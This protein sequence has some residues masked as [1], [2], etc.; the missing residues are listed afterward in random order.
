MR[1][2]HK[3]TLTGLGLAASLIALAGCGGSDTGDGLAA[4]ADPAMVEAAEARQENF[5]TLGRNFKTIKDGIDA[6]N[7][8]SD[9]VAAAIDTVVSL[10]EDMPSW[11][12]EGSGPETGTDTEAL[13]VIWEE[14]AAFEDAIL[15]FQTAADA[16]DTAS[17]TGEATG[18]KAAFGETGKTCGGCHDDFRVD[19]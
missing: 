5:K 3:R 1:I 2:A 12:P 7:A 14:P 16:L 15:A 10:S 11:F 6:G 13:P 8:T 4:D 19:D 17:E 9:E 18:I